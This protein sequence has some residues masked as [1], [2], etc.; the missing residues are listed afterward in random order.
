MEI[1][2]HKQAAY[3]YSMEVYHVNINA[4]GAGIMCPEDELDTIVCYELHRVGP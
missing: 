2:T 3:M 1:C 4:N